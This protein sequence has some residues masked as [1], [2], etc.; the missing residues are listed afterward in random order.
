M[1]FLEDFDYYSIPATSLADKK[2]KELTREYNK[3]GAAFVYSLK[4]SDPHFACAVLDWQG[5]RDKTKIYTYPP[6][7]VTDEM[8]WG[9]VAN[10][11]GFIARADGSMLLSHEGKTEP[12]ANKTLASI[13]K[14]PDDSSLDLSA[15]YL[16]TKGEHTVDP[17]NGWD[18]FDSIENKLWPRH[19]AYQLGRA[20]QRKKYA[21]R[22]IPAEALGKKVAA[23]LG[24]EHDIE[25]LVLAHALAPPPMRDGFNGY[26][27]EEPPEINC[28]SPESEEDAFYGFQSYLEGFCFSDDCSDLDF[29]PPQEKAM[30]KRFVSITEERLKAIV[31]KIVATDYAQ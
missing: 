24:F 11:Q 31:Q 10:D 1:D 21:R 27:I 13:L 16:G 22:D 19:I 14:I 7:R 2:I 18:Y 17:S 6:R 15:V 29:L 23:Q 8:S 20:L 5:E 3:A 4:N 30:I 25:A 26:N 12:L 28:G 9:L